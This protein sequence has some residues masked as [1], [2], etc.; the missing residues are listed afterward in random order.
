MRGWSLNITSVAFGPQRPI[1]FPQPEQGQGLVF[2]WG[3]RSGE[4]VDRVPLQF[5]LI[6]AHGLRKE[7]EPQ[8]LSHE[9]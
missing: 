4:G 5:E 2:W 8:E 3:D 9:D 7:D 1:P 6:M